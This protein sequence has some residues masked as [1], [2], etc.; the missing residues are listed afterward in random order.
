M[1]QV[2]KILLKVSG[3]VLEMPAKNSRAEKKGAKNA[4]CCLLWH[5]TQHTKLH[6]PRV[7][8]DDKIEASER[9]LREI[10]IKSARNKRECV[11][12]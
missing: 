8:K 7:E 10:Y 3:M 9:A 5:G 2:D 12:V 11:C 1:C 6:A 4:K